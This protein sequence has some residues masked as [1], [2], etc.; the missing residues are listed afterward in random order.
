[1]LVKEGYGVRQVRTRSAALAVLD[2]YLYDFIVMDWFMDGIGP[3]E[4]L[5]QVYRRCLRSR[6]I[7]ISAS[8]DTADAASDL[9]IR[10]WIRKP[11]D[12]A[13]LLHTL[14]R[15]TDN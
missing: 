6:V 12:Q 11:F 4:F 1:M 15:S 3:V 7:L 2:Q 13:M 9:G 14:A 8:P 10:W 5:Q